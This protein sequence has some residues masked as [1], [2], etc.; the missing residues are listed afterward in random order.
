MV[1]NLTRL[2]YF[3]AVADALSFSRAATNL[4]VSQQ[5]LSHQVGCLEREVG[6][7]LLFRTTRHVD[8]TPA[9]RA[10]LP[11]A[12]SSLAEAEAGLLGA[13]AAGPDPRYG[14]AGASA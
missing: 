2:G 10:L 13:R 12:R 6:C 9:G 8:L 5:A 7:P 3:V 4:G 11:R 14:M 1:V